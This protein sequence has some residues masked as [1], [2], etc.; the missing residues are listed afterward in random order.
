MESGLAYDNKNAR[1]DDEAKAEPDQVPP[2]EAALHCVF[3]LLGELEEFVGVGGAVEVA[4]LEAGGSLGECLFIGSE[5]FKRGFREEVLLAP[6]F[7]I[8]SLLCFLIHGC[9]WFRNLE[10]TEERVEARVCMEV[11]FVWE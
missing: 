10:I 5:V 6:S 9:V 11:G 4:V 1:A 8:A 2:V 7:P 3:A